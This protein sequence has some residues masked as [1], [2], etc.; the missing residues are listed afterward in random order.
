LDLYYREFRELGADGPPLLFLH[1][2][3]GS[4]SNWVGIVRPLRHRHLILLPD[5]RNHGRSPHHPVMDYPALADDVLRLADG[6]GLG[7]FVLIGHSMGGKVAMWL[8]L[9]EPERVIGLVSLD[10]APV[11]YPPRFRALFEAMSELPLEEL[12][13]R[14]AADQFLARRLESPELRAFLL[15]NLEQREGRWRWRVNLQAIIGQ[16]EALRGFPE[17]GRHR[18][19]PGPALFL[20]GDRSDYL[21]AE[22]WPA[23]R[24]LFPFAR[25]RPVVGAGHWVYADRPQEV[26]AG[27]QGFLRELG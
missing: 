14:E 19:F 27:L 5:L 22:H 16:R 17:P 1:G 6:L 3:L 10:M 13:N 12:P 9:Q 21:Q 18:Q 15:Q 11:T 25:L 26:L 24:D 23:I 20:Y 2:M 4:S 8:A 7:R